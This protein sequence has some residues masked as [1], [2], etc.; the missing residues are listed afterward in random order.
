MGRAAGRSGGVSQ[1]AGEELCYVGEALRREYREE[2]REAGSDET[3][4]NLDGG[5]VDACRDV[6]GYVLT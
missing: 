5:R 6:L 4:N 2:V 3:A 1:A